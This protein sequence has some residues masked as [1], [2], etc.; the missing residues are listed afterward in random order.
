[1]EERANMLASE[2]GVLFWRS[3]L[4]Y[5]LGLGLGGILQIVL[6][7]VSIAVGIMAFK[8]YRL[9][10]E[11]KSLEIASI[12]EKTKSEERDHLKVV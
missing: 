2:G 8:H 10:N 1:M 5:L 3:I 12:K 11:L 4:T 6:T 9:S 7:I